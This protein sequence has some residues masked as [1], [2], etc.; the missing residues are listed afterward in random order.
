MF[1]FESEA[2]R[3]QAVDIITPLVKS[4]QKKGKAVANSGVGSPKPASGP[5][6]ELKKA[7]LAADR[8]ACH[9]NCEQDMGACICI[10][11]ERTASSARGMLAGT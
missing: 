2:D 3:D 4:A 10:L 5:H 9:I 6:A 1:E 8:S 7:V 11:T